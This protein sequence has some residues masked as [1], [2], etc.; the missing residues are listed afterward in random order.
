MAVVESQKGPLPKKPAKY[1]S[2]NSILPGYTEAYDLAFKADINAT[3]DA[4]D[5]PASD[6]A[7][8]NMVLSRVVGYLLIELFDRKG[9]LDPTPCESVRD[10]ILSKSQQAS[11]TTH[12]VV[13]EMGRK[14]RDHLIR[15][16]AFDFFPVLSSFSRSLQFGNPP[17]G[18]WNPLNIPHA[19]LLTIS[20]LWSTISYRQMAR[21]IGL[22]EKRC[23]RQYATS[24]VLLHARLGSRA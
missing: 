21:T 1:D 12:D 8:E 16:C 23:V 7:K 18:T 20:K 9:V 22:S 24:S 14:Y 5:N 6:T 3:K 13:F 19:L 10:S 11:Q 17:W 2:W 4:S 15:A